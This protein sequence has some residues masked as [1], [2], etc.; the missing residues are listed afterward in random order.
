MLVGA[1]LYLYFNKKAWIP[2]K[3][4]MR[5][6]SSSTS[7]LDFDEKKYRAWGGPDPDNPGLQTYTY[8]YYLL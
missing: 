6:A 8:C 2:T 7:L 4:R 1:H 3:P 5:S